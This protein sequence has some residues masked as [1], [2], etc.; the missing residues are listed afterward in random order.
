[1]PYLGN[2]TVVLRILCTYEM[3]AS[4]WKL[5]TQEFRV[6]LTPPQISSV[7]AGGYPLLF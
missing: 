3:K 5:R 7:D 6:I 1:M 2:D 4:A